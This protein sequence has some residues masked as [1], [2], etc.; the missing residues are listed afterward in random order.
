MMSA[1]DLVDWE[2][3]KKESVNLKVC[4]WNIPDC[5]AKRKKIETKKKPKT[6]YAS[7]VGQ[8]QKGDTV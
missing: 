5:K 4:Q 1:F 7:S 3:P 6:G 8:L 2:Q